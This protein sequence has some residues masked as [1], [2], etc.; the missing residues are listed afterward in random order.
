MCRLPLGLSTWALVLEPASL[1]LSPMAIRIYDSLT[2]EKSP[3]KPLTPG[4]VKLYVC[5]PTVY[6]DCHIG[7]LMGP[8][9]FDTVARWLAARGYKVNFV[10]NITDIDDKIINRAIESGEAWDSIAERYTKQYQGFLAELGVETI[11][12]HPRCSDYV[13][14]MITFIEDLIAQ[15]KAYVA[16]D[17]VYF[18][19][20][21]HPGYGKLTRRKVEDM[22]A[23]S[24]VQAQSNLRHPGDFA[25]WKNAKPQEPSWDSPFGAGRPGWHIECSVMSSELLGGAFDLHGGGDDLKFPH[26]ENEIAQSEAHGDAFAS[27]WMHNGMVQYGGRKVAKSDPRM[28]D[29]AFRQ[30][31]QARWLLDTYGAPA[32]RFFLLRSAYRR[33][34]DFEPSTLEAARTGLIRMAK[35]LGSLAEE[36]GKVTLEEIQEMN[37]DATNAAHRKGFIAA[38]DDDF[39]SGEALAELFSLA[40]EARTLEPEA[41]QITLTLVRDLG[42]LLGLFRPG[43]LELLLA[44]GSGSADELLEQVAGALLEVR[45]LAREQKAFGTADALRDALLQAG[46]TVEDGTPGTSRANCHGAQTNALDQILEAALAARLAA[47]AAKDF[48][49]A[50]GLREGLAAVGISIQDGAE[51]SNWTRSGA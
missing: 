16:D 39:S 17:G 37:L 8:V 45:A 13:P 42:R 38:M 9:L 23:G 2:R 22:Q 20:Q 5:G 11:S 47:K 34:V 4:E 28:Q 6:D 7:H 41:K 15:D 48:V 29:A 18:D 49:T 43:D 35:G 50:D 32:L 10:N 14:Q 12:S 25:L 51:G 31:F 19:I 44:A 30:Q 36:P 3:L 21:K 1:I 26:H 33:P 40:Q 46:I 27:T 24:R